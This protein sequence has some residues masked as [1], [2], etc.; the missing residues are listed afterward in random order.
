MESEILPD[1]VVIQPQH[2]QV[3][4]LSDAARNVLQTIVVQKKLTQGAVCSNK[5]DSVD[6][7]IAQGVVG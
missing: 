5:R 4:K 1:L 7:L 3:L 2:L 6:T